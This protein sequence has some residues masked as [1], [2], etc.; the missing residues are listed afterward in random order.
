M[1]TSTHRPPMQQRCMSDLNGP[2]AV[3]IFLSASNA[4]AK[5]TLMIAQRSVLEIHGNLEIPAACITD[6]GFG[7]V[8]WIWFFGSLEAMDAHF[9]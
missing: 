2:Q 3:L 5:V 8:L 6:R 1:R 4:N 7:F 9:D